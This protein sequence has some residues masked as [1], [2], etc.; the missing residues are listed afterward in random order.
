VYRHAV[1]WLNFNS[2][3]FRI[4]LKTRSEIKILEAILKIMTD[5][6]ATYGHE[7]L[8]QIQRLGSKI[9]LG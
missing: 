5:C 4:N 7:C 9:S 1:L 3:G 8:S 6:F 2:A